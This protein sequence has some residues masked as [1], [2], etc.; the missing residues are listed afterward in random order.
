MKRFG[1]T[2]VAALFCLVLSGFGPVG[3]AQT[4]CLACHSD[5]TLQDAQGHS[6][7]VDGQK[8]NAS[9]HGALGCN[10]CHADVKGYPHPDKIAPVDCKTCHSDQA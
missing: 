9:V 1:S 5:A 8:F 7:G 10:A 3:R 4:D 2:L 6:V